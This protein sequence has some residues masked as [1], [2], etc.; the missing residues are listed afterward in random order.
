MEI[1]LKQYWMYKTHLEL[2]AQTDSQAL[3]QAEIEGEVKKWKNDK[4]P[5]HLDIYIDV[6]TCHHN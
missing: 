3:K 5:I 1:V 2:L 6:I 4:F